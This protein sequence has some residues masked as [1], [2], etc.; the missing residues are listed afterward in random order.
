MPVTFDKY[1]TF[2]LLRMRQS[3]LQLSE[4]TIIEQEK[5]EGRQFVALL[6]R[7]ESV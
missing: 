7:V 5:T 1:N 4:I 6:R 3:S 2:F